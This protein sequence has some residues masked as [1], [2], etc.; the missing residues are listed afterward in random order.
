MVQQG[1]NMKQQMSDVMLPLMARRWRSRFLVI[2]SYGKPKQ[3]RQPATAQ[4]S[5]G[6]AEQFHL[7]QAGLFLGR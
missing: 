7:F 3:A 4:L 1:R 5:P 6:I 2:S